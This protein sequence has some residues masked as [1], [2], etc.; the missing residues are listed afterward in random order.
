[1]KPARFIL[2]SDYTTT[3]N[4]GETTLSITIPNSITVPIDVEKY[5]IGTTT[6]KI[7]NS[8]DTFMI[9]FTSSAFPYN[10]P[11]S[12]GG[13]KPSG[14]ST[15]YAGT[16]YIFYNVS[17]N[18]NTATLEVWCYGNIYTA[19]SWNGYGQTITAHILTFKDPFSE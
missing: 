10:S 17:I 9:Y 12:M 11:G 15:T 16:D 1:M 6:A 3:R 14:A 18:G 19:T 8:A 4:T 13:T 2:N 5:T 7:G